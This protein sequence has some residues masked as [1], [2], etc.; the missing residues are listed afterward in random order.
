MTLRSRGLLKMKSI[1]LTITLMPFLLCA[2]LAHMVQEKTFRASTATSIQADYAEAFTTRSNVDCASFCSKR[3]LCLRYAI[4]KVA[5]RQVECLLET[6]N[7]GSAVA[8]KPGW[9]MYE[10]TSII[11][12]EADTTVATTDTPTTQGKYTNYDI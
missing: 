8:L 9:R 7:T 10:S 1:A 2:S 5:K 3:V 4:H 11:K 6:G 12:K